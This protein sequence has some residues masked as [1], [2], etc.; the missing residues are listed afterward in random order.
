MSVVFGLHNLP[1]PCTRTA[2]AVGVFDGV[3]WGHQAIFHRLTV[4]AAAEKLTSVALTFDR[5]PAE[6][7]A[8]AYAP[9]YVTTLDQRTELILRCGVDV[10]VV[11]EFD[12]SLAGLSRDEFVRQ[13]LLQSLCARH[14]VVGSNF[15]FGRDRAGDVRYLKSQGQRAGFFVSV[16]P[17]VIVD[18]APASSTRIRG[19]LKSGDVEAAARLLGRRFVLRGRVVGGDRVG[20]KLGFPTAN[21]ETEPRQALPGQGVYVVESQV[22]GITYRGVCSIGTKPTF[23]GDRTSVEVHLMSYEGD[24]YGRV[25]DVAFLRRLRDQIAFQSADMLAEQIR[26]DIIEAGSR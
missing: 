18:G 2:V 4:A 24:L 6:L 26:R 15:L 7:L 12:A 9:D 11:A 21:L 3:H 17:S 14:V 1:A 5:H 10:V 13:V 25:L 19:F 16:V 23:S 8:P 20:R 22:D